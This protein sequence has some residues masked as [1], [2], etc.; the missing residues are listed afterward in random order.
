MTGIP[1]AIMGLLAVIVATSL[2]FLIIAFI[3]VPL[4]KGVGIGIGYIFKFIGAAIMHVFTFIG[5]MFTDTFRAIGAV[6]AGIVFALMSVGSVVIGRW[7]SAAHFG[8][9]MQKEF[10]TFLACVYRVVLGHPLR[11]VF[12]NGLLEGLEQR[13]PAALAES[14]GADRPSRRTGQFD[15]YTIVG[16]LPGGGSG[17]RLYIAEPT[18]EKRDRIVKDFGHCPERVVIKSFAVADGSS[19]PQIVRESRALES[20]KKLGLI[21]EHELTDDRFFYAME[22]VPGESLGAT[23]RD[24]HAVTGDKGIGDRGL[25]LALGYLEDILGTL[26]QYHAGGLWHKDIKPENII[27][28]HDRAHVVDLGLVTPLRS[29]MTLTTHGTEYFRDPEM[30][31][32][33]LKGVKVH[34][35]NGA[36]FDIYAA[37]AVLFYMIENTFPSHGGLS[38][39]TRRC[40]ESVKWI[41]RRAMSDYNR[42]Y[43]SAAEMLADVRALRNSRNM[44]A[45]KPADLPSMRGGDAVEMADAPNLGDAVE[46]PEGIAFAA[47]TSHDGPSS[48]SSPESSGSRR[49]PLLKVTNWWTGEYQR[50]G[51]DSERTYESKCEAREA[52]HRAREAVIKG[53]GEARV[54]ARKIAHDMKDKNK[55]AFVAV[56]GAGSAVPPKAPPSPPFAP[57]RNL[58]PADQRQKASDQV[59]A[60]RERA[61]AMRKRAC[62]RAKQ[63]HAVRAPGERVTGAVVVATLLVLATLGGGA[64]IGGVSLYDGLQQREIARQYTT[65]ASASPDYMSVDPIA[66]VVPVSPSTSASASASDGIVEQS[67]TTRRHDG[68]IVSVTQAGNTAWSSD[69]I[70]LST[71]L[72]SMVRSLSNQTY[73]VVNNHP[74]MRDEAIQSQLSNTRS[75][76]ESLGLAALDAEELEASI[77]R[78]VD[79]HVSDALDLSSRPT[80]EARHALAAMF[81]DEDYQGPTPGLI[82][83]VYEDLRAPGATGERGGPDGEYWFA[84]PEFAAANLDSEDVDNLLERYLL[85]DR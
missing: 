85:L 7:S 20:A 52:V 63:R 8:A 43:T 68:S 9:N 11:L 27:I 10:K 22:Y 73:V 69:A 31:R 23:V 45:M 15:G 77:R 84:L 39:I 24:M 83:W 75:A 42:R 26:D 76:L 65:E 35:V 71:A 48:S 1:V 4:L 50:V 80:D 32:M 55:G 79:A 6:P 54:K 28:H 51:D 33:A 57:H 70:Q 40:P 19:L 38:S 2:A 14:P 59:K 5:G 61:R 37:G 30:V 72:Q 60:A 58:T 29:A 49:R 17:G 81:N 56:F 21:L 44:F 13:V 34:E 64:I 36:K 25:H 82:V 62:G 16:S 66:P 47:A 78:V 12:L 3:L 53:A 74:A 46:T 67:R 18:D 41:V